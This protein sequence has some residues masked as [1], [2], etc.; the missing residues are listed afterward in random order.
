MVGGGILSHQMLNLATAQTFVEGLSIPY[1]VADARR[2]C[3]RP[4]FDLAMCLF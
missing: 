2:L 4:E 3:L 1:V